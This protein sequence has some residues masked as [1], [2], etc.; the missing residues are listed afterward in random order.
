MPIDSKEFAREVARQYRDYVNPD[1][2]RVMRVTGLGTVEDHASGCF[3]WDNEG[4]QFLDM[5]GGYGVFCLGHSHPKVIAAVKQQLERMSLSSKVFFSQAQ[6][7]LAQELAR[8]TPGDLQ[9]SFFCNSGTEAV[10]GALKIA[11]LRTNRP[12]FVCTEKAFHGKS[13]GGLAVSGRPNYRKPF[14]PLMPEVR[15]VPFGDADA[16]RS[17]MDEHVAAVIIEPV[18]GEGGI[19]VAPDG[20][21]SAL[22]EICT[23]NGSLLIA[24]EVQTGFGR[25]GA[26]FAVNHWNVVPDLMTVAKALSG[27]IIPIG[28]VIGTKDVW[29]AFKGRPLIHTSTFGGSPLACTAGLAALQVIEEEGLVEKARVSGQYFLHELKNLAQEYPDICAEARGLG[30]MLGMEFTEEKYAGLIIAELSRQNIIAVYTLNQ[31]KV[32]RF[33]PELGIERCHL[34]RTIVCLKEALQNAREFFTER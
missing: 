18:Q 27:G 13:T 5:A 28:A 32:I 22:R 10:E 20:Y 34:D 19:N 1:L 30:L 11:R 12:V 33:E 24:D 7:Q 23:A 8:V 25:T 6:A 29:Q 9:Y 21:L 15:R 4:R 3:I 26:M 14:E 2:A 17:V 16:M 31:P